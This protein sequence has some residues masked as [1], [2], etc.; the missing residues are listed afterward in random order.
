MP[1]P[2]IIGESYFDRNGDYVVVA[3]SEGS[4][5]CRYDDGSEKTVDI[6]TKTRIYK[7]IL[8]EQRS[9]HPYQSPG[10]FRTLG[11]FA[12]HADFQ[13]E[14]PPQSQ[15]SFED[16]YAM[17]TGVHPELQRDGYYPVDVQTGNEKWG[18]ELRIYFPDGLC[19]IDVP[20]GI[21]VRSGSADKIVRINNNG[22]WW[23]LIGIGFRLGKHHAVAS[24]QNTVPKEFLKAFNDGLAL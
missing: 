17:L 2:F 6:E 16:R 14:V 20:D 23:R 22:L 9:L 13:A 24:I 19:K 1:H 12:R 11:F 7:N 4:I 8:G 3:I 5:T 21:E 15:S 18:P 10:Y